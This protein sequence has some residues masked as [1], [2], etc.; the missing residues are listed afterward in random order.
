MPVAYARRLIG[1]KRTSA[2]NRQLGFA[3]AFIAGAINAGGFLAVRQYTSHMTGI[4]SSMADNLA[5]GA[6]G[7]VLQ[8]LG[9]L[10]SFLFGAASTAIL[11]NFAHRRKAHSEFAIPLLL[12]ALLLLLFGLLGT[13]LEKIDGLFMPVTVMLLCFMMGL[14][15][16]LITKISRTEIRTTHVTGILTDIGIELGK[17]FYWNRT[18]S[19][20]DAQVRANRERLRVLASLATL[21]LVGGFTGAWGFSHMGYVSTVPLALLLVLLASVPALDDITIYLRRRTRKSL[22]NEG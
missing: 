17:L 11:V 12:E 19:P 2:A 15:N 9:G 16:A 8:G 10:G 22:S 1:R 7:L 18:A 4:V 3:L 6:Y 21:F 13:R 5:L 14:Q 20:Q